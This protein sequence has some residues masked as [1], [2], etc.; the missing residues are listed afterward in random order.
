MRRAVVWLL[1]INLLVLLWH[2][3]RPQSGRVAPLPVAGGDLTLLSELSG[4][5]LQSRERCWL[6]GPLVP[7][8]RTALGEVWPTIESGRWLVREL[9]IGQQLLHRVYIEPPDSVA[10]SVFLSELSAAI[11]EANYDIDSYLVAEGT[12]ADSISL[13]LFADA[14][15][16]A[17]VHAQLELLG[18]EPITA[19]ESR[20]VRRDWLQLWYLDLEEQARQLLVARFDAMALAVTENLCETIAHQK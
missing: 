15:N 12:L 4:E 16:A 17:R 14:T 13:G 2:V 11:E 5:Q 19:A 3:V 7:D 6:V 18:Y 9:G 8:A 1:A 20:S 10:G